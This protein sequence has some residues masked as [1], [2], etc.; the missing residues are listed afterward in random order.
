M[1]D[2]KLFPNLAE[3]D[4]S[5]PQKNSSDLDQRLGLY[6]VF[7][8]LYEH[9][10]ELLDE[11]LELENT[12]SRQRV[13][14][15]W[16]FIQGIV[17]GDQVALTTNLMQE[18]TVMLKQ[19]HSKWIIGRDRRAEISIPDKRLSRRHAVIQYS[20][21]LGFSL[22]DLGSTNGT[23][24]NGETAK[25]PV[26]LQDGDRIRLGS[27]SFI[28]FL[29]S[30][31][32]TGDLVPPEVDVPTSIRQPILSTEPA[33]DKESGSQTPDWDTPLSNNESD[34]SMFLRPPAPTQPEFEQSVMP[35]LS[36]D[37]KAEILDRFLQR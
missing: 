26:T 5:V 25:R 23:Y 1:L 22:T 36:T 27:L 24:V 34:T 16:Q 37:Q 15:V 30:S 33:I 10:R 8:K 32:F 18:K 20:P 11:I 4:P 3:S 17:H 21:D 31:T 13:R 35:Q 14:G 19:A 9:H 6:R 29:C 2:S 28:F 12:A 7:L